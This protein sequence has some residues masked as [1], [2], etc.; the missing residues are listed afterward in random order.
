M[1]VDK[2]TSP[3]R[4]LGL[5]PKFTTK[6]SHTSL[7]RSRSHY[8]LT[9]PRNKPQM[10]PKRKHESRSKR[11]SNPAQCRVDGP[12]AWGGQSADTGR[13]VRY[14]QADSPL[15][16]T[17]R[18]DMHSNTRTVHTSST[19]VREQL[20]LHARSTTSR[21]TIAK[22]LPAKNCWPTRSKQKRSRACDEQEEP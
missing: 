14:P 10:G 22:H 13:T 20:V 21:R 12:G 18:F 16:A 11:L 8:G 6:D 3:K 5:Y 4:E 9:N 7:P 15:I 2:N 19:K 17:E 1:G